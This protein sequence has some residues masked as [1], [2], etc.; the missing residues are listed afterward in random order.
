M[1]GDYSVGL[2]GMVKS[3]EYTPQ[4]HARGGE[5]QKGRIPRGGNLSKVS[6]YWGGNLLSC[7]RALKMLGMALIRRSGHFLFVLI[8]PMAI[9]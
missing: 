6:K 8:L 3:E 4:S 7:P 5:G 2:K 1:P 9:K